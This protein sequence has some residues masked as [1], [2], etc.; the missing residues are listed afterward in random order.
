MHCKLP[1]KSDEGVG[2]RLASG[3][4]GKT[5]GGGLSRLGPLVLPRPLLNMTLYKIQR[6]ILGRV[7]PRSVLIS[8][9]INEYSSFT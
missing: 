2:L 4:R 1:T 9:K 5:G 7:R 3:R 8:C 6:L